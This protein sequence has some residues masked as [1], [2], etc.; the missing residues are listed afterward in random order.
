MPASVTT[1]GPA[2]IFD[3]FSGIA[4]GAN[5][6]PFDTDISGNASTGAL[7]T[8]IGFGPT[9][10]FKA[11]RALSGNFPALNYQPGITKPDGTTSA[12]S[13]LMYI[14]GG[15]SAAAGVANPYTAGFGIAAAGNGGVREIDVSG[16]NAPAF[17]KLL[18]AAGTV[19]NGAAIGTGFNNRTGASLGS[20]DIQFGVASAGGAAPA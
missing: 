8:G 13:T 7:C 9:V 14:G 2:V 19:A 4:H 11:A 16:R 5:S 15:R 10:S 1:N 17:M 12:N 18:A 6:G 20:G 3:P